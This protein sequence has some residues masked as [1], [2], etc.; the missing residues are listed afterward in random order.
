[1]VSQQTASIAQQPFSIYSLFL[2]YCLQ[3][4]SNI[5]KGTGVST[6]DCRHIDSAEFWKDQYT[7]LH[8]EKK[9]LVD[10]IHQLEESQGKHEL[11][12]NHELDMGAILG[13]SRKRRAASPNGETWR[14]DPEEDQEPAN[15]DLLLQLSSYGT[16]AIRTPLSSTEDSQKPFYRY[17]DTCPTISALQLESAQAALGSC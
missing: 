13:H 6:V 14:Y 7:K 4:R 9:A 3:L 16:L 10:K 2:E 15:Q 11:L 1:M 17:E 8:L 5:K 12:N